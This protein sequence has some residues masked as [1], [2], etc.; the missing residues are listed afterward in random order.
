LDALVYLVPAAHPVPGFAAIVPATGKIEVVE[1]PDLV[2]GDGSPVQ[3]LLQAALGPTV[4]RRAP[5]GQDR[6]S[7]DAGPVGAGALPSVGARLDDLC[8]WAWRAAMARLVTE[9]RAMRQSA[10]TRLV[11]IPMGA[12]GLVPWHAAYQNSP[13]GRRY[14]VHDLVLSYS[15]SARMLCTA[16]ARQPR[17]IQSALVVGDPLGDLPFAGIE[18]QAIHQRFHRTGQ[19]LGGP[20]EGPDRIAHPDRVLEW[21]RA[22]A[23]LGASLLHLACHGRVD[24]TRPA[25]SHLVLAGGQLPARQLLEVSRLAALELGHVFLAACTTSRV[26]TDYDE[27]F[28]LATTFLAAGAHT[29]FGSLWSVPDVGTS[30]LMYLVHHFL[31]EEELAPAEAL[32]RAQL[33]MLDP[34]RQPPDE[35]PAELTAH[36]RRVDNAAPLSWAAF[37]HLGR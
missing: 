6:R 26:G 19:Y 28:S 36:C 17:P 32:H 13:S 18:A 23:G 3:K 27:A 8:R 30:L 25:D 9:T 2:V 10:P 15:P 35:M 16:A 7:R 14:A 4:R 12:L 31:Y 24:P 1:L 22:V 37:T 20:A 5:D 34:A 21:I 33:W 29:V 11:L